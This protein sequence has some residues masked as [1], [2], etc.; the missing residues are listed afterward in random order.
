MGYVFFAV[1]SVDH[2]QEFICFKPVEIGVI[3]RTS[4]LILDQGILAFTH[5]KSCGVV[6]QDIL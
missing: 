3:N 1:G 2:Q 6:G 5:L 4:S